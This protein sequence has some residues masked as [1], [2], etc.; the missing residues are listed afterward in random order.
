ML[1]TVAAQIATLPILLPAFGRLQTV[2]VPAILVVGPV[3]EVLFPLAALIGVVGVVAPGAAEAV[4]MPAV[5]GT[6]FVFLVV[7]TLAR[8]AGPGLP[9]PFLSDRAAVA[10]LTAGVAVVMTAS[11]RDG[12]RWLR[13]LW[14]S[15]AR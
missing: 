6:R 10:G 15:S 8:A 9:L 2:S 1:G 7:D 14:R 11:S 3:V 5:L 13:R 4:A 12:R